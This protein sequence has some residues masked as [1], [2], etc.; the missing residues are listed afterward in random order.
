VDVEDEREGDRRS[1]V[2]DRLEAAARLCVDE[3]GGNES[4]ESG[5]GVGFEGI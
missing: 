2:E 5:P 3:D 4:D 1:A